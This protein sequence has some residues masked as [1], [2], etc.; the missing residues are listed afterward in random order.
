MKRYFI[1]RNKR[2]EK[3]LKFLPVSNLNEESVQPAFLTQTL[4]SR[5]LKNVNFIDII[6]SPN[7]DEKEW[8]LSNLVAF[9]GLMDSVYECFD[10]YC[11]DSLCSKLELP[12]PM[13]MY[14]PNVNDNSKIRTTSPRYIEYLL[15]FCFR[16][17]DDNK[18][19]PTVFGQPFPVDTFDLNVKKIAKCLITIVAHIYHSHL[20][21]LTNIDMLSYVNTFTL[22]M[23]LF[24]EHYKLFTFDE[25]SGMKELLGRLKSAQV[26][27]SEYDEIIPINQNDDVIMTDSTCKIP[28]ENSNTSKTSV[29]SQKIGSIFSSSKLYTK[30]S[31]SKFKYNVPD[32]S[33]SDTPKI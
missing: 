31:T 32:L 1:N 14:W 6:V 33:K 17:I 16:L 23:F 15:S 3:D 13:K 29:H 22:H 12:V 30:S 5:Q 2:K 11:T 27:N 18:C 19:F 10:S 4:T 9:V 25:E 28:Q 20:Y 26:E 7:I 24:Y 8:I 21:D